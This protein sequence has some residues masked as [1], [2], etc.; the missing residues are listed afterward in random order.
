[1]L[2][3]IFALIASLT[4]TLNIKTTDPKATDLRQCSGVLIQNDQ[5][6][7]AAH[8]FRGAAKIWAKTSDGTSYELEY[9]YHDP[10]RDLGLAKILH[11]HEKHH[12]KLYGNFDK[13]DAV[14]VVSTAEGMKDTFS[15]GIIANKVEEDGVMQI[16]HTAGI[17]HGSS[18]S[19]LFDRKGRLIGI[20][21]S[22]MRGF[23]F[24]TSVEE[25]REFL[26]EA[27]RKLR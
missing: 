9:L 5:V 14:F 2:S 1:M 24:A 19:G 18:G 10:V 21:A 12:A 20:N 13:A 3:T 22:M 16:V 8:C 23:Y 17:L 11:S 15:T 26:A 6:L 27:N 4:V 7:T 25:I